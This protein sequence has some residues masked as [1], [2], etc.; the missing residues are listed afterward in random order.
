MNTDSSMNYILR[1]VVPAKLEAITLIKK[2]HL[3]LLVVSNNWGAA[4]VW[5]L[6]VFYRLCKIFLYIVDKSMFSAYKEA[7][8]LIKYCT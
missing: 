2:Q 4:W 6:L 8:Q 3:Q 5:H 7:L 1:L